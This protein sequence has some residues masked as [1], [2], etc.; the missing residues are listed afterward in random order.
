MI[1]AWFYK[2]LVEMES[3]IVNTSDPIQLPTPR[4]EINVRAIMHGLNQH[5]P[6]DI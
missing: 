3:E 2:E 4:S 1:C 5:G 6:I